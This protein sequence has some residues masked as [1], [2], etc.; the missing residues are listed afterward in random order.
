MWVDVLTSYTAVIET[1]EVSRF[2]DRGTK[3]P[4]GLAN[5]AVR[6]KT[7]LHGDILMYLQSV[8]SEIHSAPQLEVTEV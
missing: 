2:F 4:C 8:L 3:R 1:A 6:G 5:V 7:F